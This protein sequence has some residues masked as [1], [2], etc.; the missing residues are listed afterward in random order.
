MFLLSSGYILILVSY[1]GISGICLIGYGS[2]YEIDA[3]REAKQPIL[4]VHRSGECSIAVFHMLINLERLH[5]V[6]RPKSK[7]SRLHK[8]IFSLSIFVGYIIV[9]IYVIVSKQSNTIVP[10]ISGLLIILITNLCSLVLEIY[11]FSLSKTMFQ[12]TKGLIDL[13]KRYEIFSSIKI[14]K[15]FLPASISSIFFHSSVIAL[16]YGARFITDPNVPG[17]YFLVVNL[18]WNLDAA[19]FP[20]FFISTNS[21]FRK[22]N[23]QSTP[24]I[25]IRHEQNDYFRQFQSSWKL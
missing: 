21:K 24:V 20:W 8:S 12:K 25:I 15:S 16:L 2:F 23:R 3:C 10:D 17:P 18:C 7:F 13:R 22:Q 5:T 6:Q 19:L 9:L 1:L 14:T 4:D 11:L